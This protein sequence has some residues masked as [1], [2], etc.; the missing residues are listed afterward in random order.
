MRM[1]PVPHRRGSL[2]D[3]I[4]HRRGSLADATDQPPGGQQHSTGSEKDEPAVKMSWCPDL[5]QALQTFRKC[6]P[7]NRVENPRRHRQK[8]SA[9]LDAVPMQEWVDHLIVPM[10]KAV[11]EAQKE[12]ELIRSMRLRIRV[13]RKRKGHRKVVVSESATHPVDSWW[14]VYRWNLAYKVSSHV[15]MM[16]SLVLT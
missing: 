16:R 1:S 4:D 2:V 10:Y 14:P 15:R 7:D 13:R 5:D 11:E 8:P 12:M 9:E 6:V 3:T